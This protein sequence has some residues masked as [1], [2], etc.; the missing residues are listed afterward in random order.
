MTLAVGEAIWGGL[1]MTINY[2][3]S[4]TVRIDLYVT[5]LLTNAPSSITLLTLV[6][7]HA[8]FFSLSA[9]DI[10]TG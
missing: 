7:F 8:D 4:P 2:R 9:F 3:F 5:R 6:S 1:A 10:Y